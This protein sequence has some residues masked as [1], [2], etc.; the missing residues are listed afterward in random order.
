MVQSGLL[1]DRPLEAPVSNNTLPE[2]LN[3]WTDRAGIQR[4]QALRDNHAKGILTR[5]EVEQ[6]KRFAED[7]GMFET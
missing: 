4:T 7:C 3:H 5:A 2:L 6:M 1:G